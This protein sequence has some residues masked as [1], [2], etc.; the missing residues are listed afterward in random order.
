MAART[1]HKFSYVHRVRGFTLLETVVALAI[2]GAATAIGVSL[3]SAAAQMRLEQRRA[4]LAGELARAQLAQMRQYPQHFEWPDTLG[5]SFAEVSAKPDSPAAGLARPV[6][7]ATAAGSA[8]SQADRVYDGFR[9][10]GFLR[11]VEG[12]PG[13][14]EVVLAVYP[15]GR[16]EQRAHM[17]TA[18]LPWPV[19]GGT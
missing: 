13:C 12:R 17:L 18:L 19:E 9:W 4:A 1:P 6:L 16:A 11:R 5:A 3:Y 2:V 14:C 8:L 10:R 7:Q 15:P